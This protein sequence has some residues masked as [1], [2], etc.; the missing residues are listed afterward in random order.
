MLLNLK[1]SPEKR[2]ETAFGVRMVSHAAPTAE[3]WIAWKKSKTSLS[4]HG[5]SVRREG[6]GW[7]VTYMREPYALEGA[8]PPDEVVG[9]TLKMNRGLLKAQIP[10]TGRLCAALWKYGSALDASETGT[11]KTYCGMALARE[12]GLVPAIVC[13]KSVIPSWKKVAAYFG[14][15]PYFVSNYEACKSKK[16]PHGV[17]SKEEAAYRWNLG[18]GKVL[19]IMDEAHKC[20]GEYTQNAK[21][22]IAAKHQKI[23][24]LILTATAGE[25]PADLRALGYHMGLH[26]LH[27][28]RQWVLGM[29]GYIDE[30]GNWAC[31]DPLGAMRAIH[32]HLFPARGSRMTIEDL[33]DDFPKFQISADLYPVKDYNR[34]NEAYEKLI[35]DV[36]KLKAKK[37]AGYQAAILTLNLRYRQMAEMMKVD[38]LAELAKDYHENH[39][40]V[41]IFVNFVETLMALQGKLKGAVLIH[42]QQSAEEREKAIEAFQADKAPYIISTI[43]AGGA[44]ISLHDLHGTWARVGLVCPTYAAR[45]IKQV[46]GRLP[47]AGALTPSLY[48]IVYAEGT[49]EEKVCQSM[50]GKLAAI[51]SL[52]DGD[53]MEPD[54]LGV[55]K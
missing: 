36:E 40:A 45:D 1:F 39:K 15:R 55:L 22:L 31:I 42:G 6:K 14:I 48:R 8:P 32:S 38:L 51:S 29:D 16:F 43:Q 11:G 21:M 5:L 12:L 47:R 3:F 49:I 33:G 2:L 7:L 24:C 41:A 37:A 35:A 28:F 23:P 54:L 44:G 9:Y 4:E 50:A 18:S 13:P 30:H 27:D 52:N 34:Q 10:H 19:L 26:S 17:W 53:L 20:K 46:L 25:Q